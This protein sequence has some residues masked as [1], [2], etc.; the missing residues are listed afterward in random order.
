MLGIHYFNFLRKTVEAPVACI[1]KT[2]I[3]K[4]IRGVKIRTPGG[5]VATK[6]TL[7]DFRYP[8]NNSV[9]SPV[10]KDYDVW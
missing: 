8:R 6:V 10:Y 7:S 5:F 3:K 4:S 2:L 9:F 1:L